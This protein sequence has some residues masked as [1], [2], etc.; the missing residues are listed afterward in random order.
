MA[1][2]D[3]HVLLLDGRST[4]GGLQPQRLHFLDNYPSLV[5]RPPGHDPPL[6]ALLQCRRRLSVL[7]PRLGCSV[8][9][10]GVQHWT[11]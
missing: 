3:L 7:C 11:S 6:P 4:G 1:A 5:P 8:A 2:E 10:G 9:N